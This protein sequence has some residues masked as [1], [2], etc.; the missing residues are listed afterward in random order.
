MDNGTFPK[1][2]KHEVKKMSHMTKSTTDPEVS[3]QICPKFM[4]YMHDEI[5]IYFAFKSV[6]HL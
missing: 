1:V 2:L 3:F 4:R 5:N 6:Q